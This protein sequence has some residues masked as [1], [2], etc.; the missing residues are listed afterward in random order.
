ML[1]DSLSH[2]KTVRKFRW[3]VIVLTGIVPFA[4]LFAGDPNPAPPT[5]SGVIIATNSQKRLDWTPYPAASQY[6]VL[7]GNQVAGPLAPV[8][9][10]TIQRRS[11]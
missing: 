4:A 5:I 10:G 3:L 6:Q 1:E 7:S 9:S 11:Q 8:N 2:M